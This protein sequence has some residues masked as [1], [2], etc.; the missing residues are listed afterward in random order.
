[1]KKLNAKRFALV[2]SLSSGEAIEGQDS[3]AAPIFQHGQDVYRNAPNE[4][5]LAMGIA[6]HNIRD[7]P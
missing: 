1:V 5:L 2:Y 3:V 7:A 6:T 4:I